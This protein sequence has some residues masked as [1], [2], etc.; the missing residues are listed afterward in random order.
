MNKIRSVADAIVRYYP[1]MPLH[2]PPARDPVTPPHTMYG[3]IRTSRSHVSSRIC[4]LA[5]HPPRL[6]LSLLFPLAHH[7]QNDAVKIQENNRAMMRIQNAFVDETVIVEPSRHFIKEGD[8][9]QGG[10][11]A[12]FFLFSDAFVIG[13]RD[14]GGGGK[15]SR[16]KS[17]ESGHGSVRTHRLLAKAA[18]DSIQQ[19]ECSGATVTIDG[20]QVRVGEWGGNIGRGG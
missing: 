13:T 4:S 14:V 10:I 20:A 11:P 9:S 19:C 16:K 15:G 8:A 5:V 1:C 7:P 12:S 3:P 2:A 6:S 18:L 17:T